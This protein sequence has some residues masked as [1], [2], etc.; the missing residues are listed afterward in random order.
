MMECTL[1]LPGPLGPPRQ[2]MYLGLRLR[3]Y[4]VERFQRSTN[5]DTRERGRNQAENALLGW[6]RKHVYADTATRSMFWHSD[7]FLWHVKLVQLVAPFRD[8]FLVVRQPNLGGLFFGRISLGS[9]MHQIP[10]D[11]GSFAGSYVCS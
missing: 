3:K 9:S 5:R 8:S 11:G 7:W 10:Y 2:Q 1:L 6:L 4:C